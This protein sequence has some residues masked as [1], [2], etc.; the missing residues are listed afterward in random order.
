MIQ[1]RI[2]YSILGFNNS[3]LG[4]NDS[5]LGFNDSI[6]DTMVHDQF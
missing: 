2:Q 5:I 4:F 3:I 6:Q 1:S